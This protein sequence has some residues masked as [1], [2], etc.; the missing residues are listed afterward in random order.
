MVNY[1]E[2]LDEFLYEETNLTPDDN[3][4]Y[5]YMV[6]PYYDDALSADQVYECMQANDPLDYFYTFIDECW[7]DGISSEELDLFDQFN[8]WLEKQ[9]IEPCDDIYVM[10][11]K[12]YVG[13]DT[14]YYLK[15]SYPCRLL[16]DSGDGAVDFTMNPTYANDWEG[17]G[18]NGED[19]IGK[20]ASLVWIAETQGYSYED[21]KRALPPN[22]R[23][24]LDKFLTSIRQEAINTA[25]MY[26]C[27]AFLVTVTL[28]DLLDYASGKCSAVKVEHST[29]CG[30]FDPFQGSGSM[31]GVDLNTDVTIPKDY[32]YE[33]VPD[34]A[35]TS[36]YG[37]M[38]VYGAGNDV[39]YGEVTLV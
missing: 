30:L 23:D 2:L 12:V 34:K 37:I 24:G 35:K 29:R 28:Q 11:D 16:V 32:I 5:N 22:D 21:V 31:L 27:F 13:V 20:E 19:G 18:M 26:N 6:D 36:N 8:Q 14:S 33:F 7:T 17:Q 1:E 4:V 39:F 38:D 25:S 3:G 10:L 9:G 15:Q